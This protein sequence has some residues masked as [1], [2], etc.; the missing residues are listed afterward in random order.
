MITYELLSAS[1][2]MGMPALSKT[3]TNYAQRRLAATQLVA[4]AA[5]FSS[6]AIL[7]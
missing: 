3:A 6:E 4:E 5:T 1:L 7:F 2:G